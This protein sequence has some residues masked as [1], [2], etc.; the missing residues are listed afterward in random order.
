MKKE[1]IKKL[2]DNTCLQIITRQNAEI[3]SGEYNTMYNY[4]ALYYLFDA[5]RDELIERGV[6]EF[7]KMLINCDPVKKIKDYSNRDN[8]H[9]YLLTYT[10]EKTT[11]QLFNNFMRLVLE[12]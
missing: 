6:R 1:K 8:I 10:Q 12:D 4:D 7:K 5:L 2:L 9:Y 3:K 11:H